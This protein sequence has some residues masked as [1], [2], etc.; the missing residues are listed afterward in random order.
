MQLTKEVKKTTGEN[1]RNF[2]VRAFKM[3]Q[4]PE[5]SLFFEETSCIFG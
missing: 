3:P 5:K 1:N 2:Y 4:A